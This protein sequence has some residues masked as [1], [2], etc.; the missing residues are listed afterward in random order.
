[1]SLQQFRRTCALAVLVWGCLGLT[2]HGASTGPADTKPSEVGDLKT[3]LGSYLAGRF[4]RSSH[5]TRDA[6][7][8][9]E[10][11]LTQDP[12]NEALLKYAFVSEVSV[13]NWD[14][15]TAIAQKLVKADPTHRL[16][17][18]YLGVRDFRANEF[19]AA[20]QHFTAAG[21]GPIGELT[22][23]LA[24]AWG[25]VGKQDGKNALELLSTVKQADWAQH[26]LRFHRALIADATGQQVTARG[27]YER[28]FRTDARSLRT[29][30]AYARHALHWGRASL[31]EEVLSKHLAA[32]QPG[33]PLASALRSGNDTAL[34]VADA[35]EG[36][37][38]VF[39]GLGEVLASEGGIDIGT[40]YLQL[41]LLLRPGQPLALAALATV[42]ETTKQY[43][44][45]IATYD[46]ISAGGPL[47]V[48]IQIRKAFNHNLLDRVDEAK[49]LLEKLGKSHPND[50]RI[51]D[52]LGNIMRARKRFSEAAG[53]YSQAIKLIDK[54]AK[55]NW[56]QYYS[57]G[58]CYERMKN[59]P[60][61]EADL[62]KAL[63]LHPDQPLVLNYLG[64][65]WVDQNRNLKKA[66]QYI[67]KAVRLK[68]DDGYFI[69]SLGWAHYRQGEFQKA[70]TFLERA[71]E[72]RPE[73]PTIND[74]L[75][76]ALWRVGRRLEAKFQWTQALTL[77]PE[78]EEIDRIKR[79]LEEGLPPEKQAKTR[80]IEQRR[81][82]NIR[83]RRVEKADPPSSGAV[84]Q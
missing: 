39:Y 5:A 36:L 80:R 45:A 38:E 10:R 81:A 9:Y 49:S 23:A 79:K 58:V 72:L 17:R 28:I 3:Q 74:H 21:T 25:L 26:Y 69:D 63:A 53:Y 61:A 20:D 65:S 78:P 34:L 42:Y 60:A 19:G 6:A 18:L 75:G 16:A 15:A 8:F 70:A 50:I 46:R 24:R 55:A 71:V 51:P 35:Q 54:P 59:W 67:E 27:I 57:R 12:D 68:P 14:R 62:S 84:Q 32:T 83:Q 31:A 30:L 48:N 4:A 40:I 2:A 37:A 33:H 7:R 56:N 41:A 66:M 11:A 13:A 82:N 52:A 76:D 43:E 73:D 1:M 29:S 44:R 47:D 22:S 77:K 64:Y